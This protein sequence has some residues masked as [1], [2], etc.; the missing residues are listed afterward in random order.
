MMLMNGD[1]QE[2][3]QNP[4]SKVLSTA[5][6]EKTP[7][8]QIQDLYVSFLS[9]NP[10]PA[11]VAEARA[12]LASGLSPTDLTWVLFNSRKSHVRAVTLTIFPC[13]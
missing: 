3:L 11:E 5:L 9:R 13:P 8:A 7:E 2:V 12:A 1:A 4:K 6:A 10:K